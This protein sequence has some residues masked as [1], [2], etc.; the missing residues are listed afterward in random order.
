MNCEEFSQAMQIRL[1]DRL[2]IDGDRELRAHLNNCESCRIQADAW[3]R[4]ALV[5][6]P[7]LRESLRHRRAANR[8]GLIAA[9]MALAAGVIFAVYLAPQFDRSSGNALAELTS[10]ETTLDIAGSDSAQSA[11]VDPTVWWESVRDKDWIAQAMPAVESV[12]EGVA[13]LGRSLMCA[14]TLLT[15]G[16]VGEHTS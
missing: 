11:D 7:S 5:V 6:D 13:P 3:N 1:D 4:I 14:V 16:P 12:R 8:A 15:T 10:Q 9:T 2:P